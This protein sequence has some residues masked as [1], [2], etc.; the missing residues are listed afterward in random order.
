MAITADQIKG[1]CEAE[2]DKWK[3]DCSGFVKAV[4]QDIGVPLSGQANDIVDFLEQSVA[5][6]KLGTDGAAAIRYATM[7]YFVIAGLKASP[8]GHIAVVV[9]SP[10]QVYPVGYWGRLGSAGRKN[11]TLNWSWTH[12][13]LAKV[14]YYAIKR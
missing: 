3:S 9:K 6:E 13:D 12:A 14:R 10:P 2:W 5:W 4:A 11:T 1:F 8:N 7:D